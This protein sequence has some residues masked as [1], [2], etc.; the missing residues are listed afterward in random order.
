M[1]IVWAIE[2][3]RPYGREAKA[4]DTAARRLRAPLNG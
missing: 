4:V 2:A 3:P 1:G